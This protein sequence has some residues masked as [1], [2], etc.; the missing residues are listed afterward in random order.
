[1]KKNQETKAFSQIL[2]I[3]RTHRAGALASVNIEHLLSRWEIGA[4]ISAKIKH[5]GWGN[6]TIDR[7]VD[8]IHANAPDERGYG[9][10]NLYNMVSVY[11]AFTSPEFTA[12]V[13]KYGDSIVQSATGQIM[14]PVTA[15]LANAS[16][17]QTTAGQI[18]QTATAQM[19]PV[20]IVQ[21]LS[22]QFHPLPFVLA[23]SSF[24][25]LLE[26]VNRTKTAQE[27]LFYVVYAFRERLDTRTLRKRLVDDAFSAVL[28]GSKTNFS[29]ALKAIY[30]SAP[31]IIPDAALVDFLHLPPKH[32]ES[33]LRK[34][35]VANMK[36]FILSIGRDFLFVGEEFPV[37]VGGS[38]FHIDLLFYHRALRCLVAFEL[39]AR[40][41]R[42]SDM[43]QLEFYLEALDRDVKRADENPSVGVLLCKSADHSMVEYALSRTMSPAMVAEYKRV[44]IPREVLQETFDR[45]LSVSIAS[46]LTTRKDK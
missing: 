23:V 35:I 41:F 13:L 38:D 24:S 18:V 3:I 42:P 28:G 32:S 2:D 30:P 20:G 12:L 1:M 26:I 39:K 5:D 7:L 25:N 40:A 34:G 29:K 15:Q 19:P 43:G 9:R 33:R 36:G 22:A 8:Y 31:A 4:Y 21:T 27:R 10:R 16:K 17:V 46:S 11:E 37:K 45:Y 6:A 44:M 14:Q